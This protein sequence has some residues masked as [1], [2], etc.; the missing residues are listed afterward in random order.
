M[1]LMLY[2][3]KTTKI[4]IEQNK[5]LKS[6]ESSPAETNETT[7]KRKLRSTRKVAPKKNHYQKSKDK[8]NTQ[9]YSRQNFIH[10]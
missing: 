4:C 10:Q 8:T 9:N 1:P 2:Y 3:I 5:K 7:P 6:K